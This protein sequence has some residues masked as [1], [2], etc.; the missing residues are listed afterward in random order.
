MASKFYTY[1]F[2][3]SLTRDF[4]LLGFFHD[5]VSHGPLDIPLAPFQ[6]LTKICGDIRNFMFIAGD[7]LFAGVDHALDKLSPVSLL[8]AINYHRVTD[9]G[10]Q[11]LSR[12]FI[13]FMT[14]AINISPVITTPAIIYEKT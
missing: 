4:R 13:D 10:D 6:K 11:A 7:K 3:G 12:I 9:T 8:P 1:T 2:K 5:P 14:P